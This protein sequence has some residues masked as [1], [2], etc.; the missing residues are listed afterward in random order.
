MCRG[1]RVEKGAPRGRLDSNLDEG[2]GVWGSSQWSMGC[3]LKDFYTHLQAKI[4]SYHHPTPFPACL[5][6]HLEFR[7]MSPACEHH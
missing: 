6:F 7:G 4:N 3:N 2:G 1:R 5:G